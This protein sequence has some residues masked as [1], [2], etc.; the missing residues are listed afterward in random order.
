[1]L[2]RQ[3]SHQYG[4]RLCPEVGQGNHGI[5]RRQIAFRI[6][7]QLV[8]FRDRAFRFGAEFLECGCCSHFKDKLVI[9]ENPPIRNVTQPGRVEQLL[10]PGRPLVLDPNQQIGHCVGSDVADSLLST[11]CVTTMMQHMR[12]KLHHPMTQPLP[13]ILRLPRAN[14]EYLKQDT[15]HQNPNEY[16]VN[17]VNSSLAHGANNMSFGAHKA[18]RKRQPKK[19]LQEQTE[20]TERGS[21]FLMPPFP[22]L[23]PVKTPFVYFAYF[24]V[25]HPGFLCLFVPLCGPVLSLRSLR[26]LRLVSLSPGSGLSAAHLRHLRFKSISADPCQSVFIRG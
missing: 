25:N 10:P 17:Q 13:L 23:P 22:Q 18:S 9:L 26:S 20:I 11:L 3:A 7:H 1:M 15:E 5:G 4:K 19:F 14:D 12:T 8:K 21:V 2:V 24:V 16:Q 6:I